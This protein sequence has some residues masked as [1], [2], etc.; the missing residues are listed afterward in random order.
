MNKEI[1]TSASEMV[2][3]CGSP[4]ETS[5]PVEV[6]MSAATDQVDDTGETVAATDGDSVSESAPGGNSAAVDSRGQG[7][8]LFVQLFRLTT[9]FVPIAGVLVG[10]YFSYAYFFGSVPI[11]EAAA[12]KLGIAESAP[13]EESKVSQMLQQTR[14]VVASSN[15]RVLTANA[16]ADDTVDGLLASAD[17]VVA[18]IKTV[19]RVQTNQP[20]PVVSIM[21][22]F[23][24]FEAE[25]AVVKTPPQST[26]APEPE[27]LEPEVISV[28]KPSG[29]FLQWVQELKIGGVRSGSVPRALINGLTLKVGS[30]ANHQL[31]I[32]FEG[33]TNDG[34]A[35]VFRDETNAMVTKHF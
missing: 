25:R 16:L 1:A 9:K 28:V 18:T 23:S 7:I 29:V 35:L 22:Q 10:G 5:V 11:V 21:D 34:K 15:A 13:R 30:K 24:S 32:T 14:D 2:S 26:F 6:P 12:V 3:D 33:L 31:G 20:A 4:T 17:S 27:R 8:S 19:P